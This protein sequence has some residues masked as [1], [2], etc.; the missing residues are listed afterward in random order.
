MYIAIVIIYEN[1]IYR[2]II[3]KWYSA[4][5]LLPGDEFK[6]QEG[7][8]TP[9]FI[10]VYHHGDNELMTNMAFWDGEKFILGTIC[11]CHT[12]E[13]DC[14]YSREYSEECEITHWL[15]IE[16]PEFEMERYFDEL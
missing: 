16:L 12:C 13:C 7:Y 5:N 10:V 11:Y 6:P 8:I 14:N 3:M 15:P 9:E 2:K 4:K 1:F